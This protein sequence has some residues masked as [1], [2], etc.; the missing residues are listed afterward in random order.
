MTKSVV[1]P[2]SIAPNKEREPRPFLFL[3]PM[4]TAQTSEVNFGKDAIE[5]GLGFSPRKTGAN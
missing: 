2:E 1:S 4:P 5:K 3:E